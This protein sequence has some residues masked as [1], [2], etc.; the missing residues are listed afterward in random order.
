MRCTSFTLVDATSSCRVAAAV[1][2]ISPAPPP[3][4]LAPPIPHTPQSPRR[5]PRR[6]RPPCAPSLHPHESAQIGQLINFYRNWFTYIFEAKSIWFDLNRPN[7]FCNH[8]RNTLVHK[9]FCLPQ[10]L[11]ASASSSFIIFVVV[12]FIHARVLVAVT[13]KEVKNCL[14]LPKTVTRYLNRTLLLFSSTIVP[15]ISTSDVL[16]ERLHTIHTR[17]YSPFF[18]PSQLV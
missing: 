13:L 15:R 3:P 5:S 12:P 16:G 6:P 8:D 4:P 11:Q 14:L 18:P 1:T 10:T 7:N 17:S 9:E 2:P